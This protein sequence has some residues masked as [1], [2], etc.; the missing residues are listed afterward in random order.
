MATVSFT[1]MQHG[2]HEDYALLQKLEPRT[3]QKPLNG[4]L[5]NSL[6]KAK[7]AWMGILLAV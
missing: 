7:T 1:Q 6:D 3:M 2:T 4:Y 5:T